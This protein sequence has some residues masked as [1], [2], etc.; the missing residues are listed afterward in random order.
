MKAVLAGQGF[1]SLSRLLT[2]SFDNLLL[3]S[4]FLTTSL[5][6]NQGMLLHLFSRNVV[7]YLKPQKAHSSPVT[8]PYIVGLS[9]HFYMSVKSDA[10]C[11]L[12]SPC[13]H[14]VVKPLNTIPCLKI[15]IVHTV[16]WLFCSSWCIDKQNWPPEEDSRCLPAWLRALNWPSSDLEACS[17]EQLAQKHSEWALPHSKSHIL[18]KR[19][20]IR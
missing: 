9:Q 19:S 11:H 17:E 13:P 4:C 1:H 10:H 7:L 5:H 2:T 15:V 8:T 16:I 3:W 14:Y 18:L 6:A 12:K 20:N